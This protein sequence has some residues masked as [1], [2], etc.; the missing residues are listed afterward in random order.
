MKRRG[1]LGALGAIFGAPAE[2]AVATQVKDTQDKFRG[3]PDLPPSPEDRIMSRYVGPAEDF[4]CFTCV[5]SIDMRN[6]QY[7]HIK[8]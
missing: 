4:N 6:F 1:F 7:G 5:P 8:R 3:L 2:A